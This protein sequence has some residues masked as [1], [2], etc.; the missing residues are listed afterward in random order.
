MTNHHSADVSVKT[1]NPNKSLVNLVFQLK[2][3]GTSEF[4]EKT[5][6]CWRVGLIQ[7]EV[8][9]DGVACYTDD[10]FMILVGSNGVFSA[11]E[12]PVSAVVRTTDPTQRNVNFMV[13]VK[14]ETSRPPNHQTSRPSAH[15]DVFFCLKSSS[16]QQREENGGGALQNGGGAFKNW[17]GAFKNGGGALKNGGGALTN[18]GGA[19]KNGGG[20]HQVELTLTITQ[21]DSLSKLFGVGRGQQPPDRLLQPLAGPG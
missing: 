9:F 16:D 13:G 14:P 6:D 19:V 3:G 18:A 20:A 7:N 1:L 8:Q 10:V 12:E 4:K 5:R 11:L 2:P 15:F 17:V 21:Q